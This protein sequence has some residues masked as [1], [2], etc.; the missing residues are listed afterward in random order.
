MRVISQWYFD[1]DAIMLGISLCIGGMH[2]KHAVDFGE[3]LCFGWRVDGKSPVLEDVVLYKQK[4]S[5]CCV[6]HAAIE[7]GYQTSDPLCI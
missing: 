6:C 3:Q 5:N 2:L 7:N 4:D 1:E